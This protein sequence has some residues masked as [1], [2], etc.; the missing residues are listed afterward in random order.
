MRDSSPW[1]QKE[2]G[3]TTSDAV[4]SVGGLGE[5]K[6]GGASLAW[7]GLGAPHFWLYQI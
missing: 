1:Q 5:R 2:T 3:N 6:L 4:L 7:L